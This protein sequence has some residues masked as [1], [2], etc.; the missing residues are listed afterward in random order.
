[1]GGDK[2]RKPRIALGS[3]LA[4]AALI[5]GASPV[6]ATRD[7][8][9]RFTAAPIEGKVLDQL[10][11]SGEASVAI[12]LKDQADLSAAYAMGEDARGR[13]VYKTLKSHAERTQAPIKSLLASRGVSYRSY[14]VANVLYATGDRAL[15]ESLAAR[16]DVKTIE[17]NAKFRG[18]P[19]RVDAPDEVSSPDTVEPGV[20]KVN[21]DDLWALGYTGQ[22]IVIANQDTGTRWTHNAL[23]PKYR[24]WN[25]SVANHNY[26]WHDSIHTGGGSCGVNTQAPCD[27]NGHGTHTTGTTSGDDGAGNQIGVAPGAKW[28]ACRNMDQGDRHTG[29]V[30]R[31]LPVLPGPDRPERREPRSDASASRDEQ[32]LDCPPSEGC[33]P[34][35]LQAIVENSEAAGIF[36]EASAGNGGSGC[37]TV[38]DPP[39]I[40]AATYST[41]AMNSAT[42]ALASFSSRGPVTSDGSG[43]MKP[44]IVAPGVNVRSSIYTADNAYQGSGWSGT[45]MAGP[46]VVGVVALLWSARPELSRNIAATKQLL[47]E[48]ANPAVSVPNNGQGCGGIAQVPNNH[49]GYG[50]V[51]ALAAY[52]GGLVGTVGPGNTIDLK[53]AD[54]T[55]VTTLP[56]GEYTILVRDL[57]SI[58]NYHLMGPGVDELTDVAGMGDVTWTVTFSAG[59]TSTS[60]TRTQ[61]R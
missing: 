38:Q 3:A 7:S 27:D 54:G 18:V 55:P 2:G 61:P 36:V 22:G 34:T 49:I 17:S 8:G 26:N 35:T 4:L 47:S 13:Y 51:D 50:L 52:D 23:K 28:I 29:H 15:I 16:S 43:R 6:L 20:M 57:A 44:D 14:W 10:A 39:A 60:A 32:Q 24:G 41:G 37:N 42:N 19:E 12:L 5:A 48:T 1:M 59:I 45:S 46:H 21:G 56:A 9:E 58:H 33:A 53:H 25:G 11:A 30:H 31:V 40:Y